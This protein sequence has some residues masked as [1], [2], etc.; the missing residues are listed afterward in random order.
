M[1]PTA[2]KILLD[3][4]VTQLNVL[5]ISRQQKVAPSLAVDLPTF[6]DILRVTD[7][8]SSASKSNSQD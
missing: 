1:N 5:K 2:I 8:A 4:F 6:N 7:V 3:Y